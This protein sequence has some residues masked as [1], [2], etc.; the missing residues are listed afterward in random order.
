MKMHYDKIA[1]A[2]YIRLRDGKIKGTVKVNDRLMVDVDAKGNTIGVELL[3][4]DS[5][6]R[7]DYYK[8]TMQSS[9]MLVRRGGG[10]L[11]GLALTTQ[12]GGAFA[13]VYFSC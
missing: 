2:M 13:R 4:A 11:L 5:F 9:K 7:R 1:D 8:N 6:W 12:I 10:N 3:E